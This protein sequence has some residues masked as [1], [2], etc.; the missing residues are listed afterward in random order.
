MARPKIIGAQTDFSAGE[1]DPD[2]KRSD[3]DPRWKTGGRQVGNWRVLNSGKLV[4]R[5]GKRALFQAFGRVEKFKIT[6]TTTFY[7]VFAST[8]VQIF[9]SNGAVVFSGVGLPWTIANVQNI[10]WDIFAQTIYITFPGMIPRTLT[11]DGTTW[12]LAFYATTLAAAQRRTVFYRISPPSVTMQPSAVTGGAITLTFSSP[13]AVAGMVGTLMRYIDNQILIT[14]YVNPTTLT[15]SVQQQLLGANTIPIGTIVGSLAIGDVVIGSLSKQQGIVTGTGAGTITV[16]LIKPGLGY[17]SAGSGSPDTIIGP[18]GFATV[19]GLVVGGV[20][21]QAVSLWDEEVFNAF[22]G[23]PASVRVDQNRLIFANFPAVPSGIAWS[24]IGLPGD[25]YPEAL[26]PDNAIFELVPGKSQ[27]LY[28]EPGMESSEFIFC[29]NAIYYVPISATNPLKPGSVAF[30]LVSANGANPVQPRRVKEVIVYIGAGT[31]TT[32]MAIVSIGS[33][34]RPYEPRALSDLHVH[35]FNNPIAIAAP[36]AD[37]LYPEDYIYVLNTDGTVALGKYDIEVGQIKVTGWWLWNSFGTHKWISVLGGDVIFCSLY[38]PGIPAVAIIEELDNSLYLDSAMFYNAAPTALAPPLVSQGPLWWLAGGTVEVMDQ[39]TRQMGTYT[40]DAN[41]FLIPQFVG[42]EDL[43]SL[44]LVVGQKWTATFEPFVPIAPPGQD[45]GQRLA[46]RRVAR[47]EVYVKDSTG[48]V[49]ARLFAGPL[50]LGGPALGAIVNT[51][52]VTTWNQDDDP[53][54]AP[55]QR[56]QSYMWR[57]IGR[58]H[59]PRV[60]IIKDTPGPLTIEEIGLQSSV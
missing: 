26:S 30:N 58:A 37:T 20:A 13:I 23:Y 44:T 40:V 9:D 14:A 48:F 4:N 55:P 33:Y 34:T 11:W 12:T 22:R 47:I 18:Y 53:T 31:S 49:F 10:V 59:D 7:I 27:V 36:P 17:F 29:D 35:L 54:L 2:I 32:I 16:Q 43:T 57:P 3:H 1:L 28:I 8:T 5:P 6:P 45:V 21:P 50:R 15:G 46:P 56:E 19:T 25:L 41:G 42:G 52:R 24:A 39:S 60:A 51:R 38:A